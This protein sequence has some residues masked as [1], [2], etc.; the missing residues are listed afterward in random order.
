MSAA[1]VSPSAGAEQQG[2]LPCGATRQL[3][4]VVVG[5]ASQL[6]YHTD[7]HRLPAALDDSPAGVGKWLATGAR[8]ATIIALIDVGDGATDG[9]RPDLLHL[10]GLASITGS[11]ERYAAAAATMFGEACDN[12]SGIGL[13]RYGPASRP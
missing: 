13:V 12:L 10:A 1:T 3:I 5:L 6:G 11:H 8:Y 2:V 9:D 4:D 7:L